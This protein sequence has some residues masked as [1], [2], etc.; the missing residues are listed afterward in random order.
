LITTLP[1]TA[2]SIFF[3]RGDIVSSV[4]RFLL[5]FVPSS[6]CANLE[7]VV[8]K[9]GEIAC[10]TCTLDYIINSLTSGIHDRVD[11]RIRVK[12]RLGRIGNR[13]TKQ[14]HQRNSIQ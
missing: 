1:R 11:N 8:M 12:D 4:K 2:Y 13:N 6:A 10:L 9:Q 5:T 7:A 14:Q 3:N